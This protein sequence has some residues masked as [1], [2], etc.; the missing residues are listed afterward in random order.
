MV[1]WMALKLAVGILDA[2]VVVQAIAGHEI[3][4]RT[5]VAAIFEARLQPVPRS[6]IHRDLATG[7]GDAGL[8]LDVDDAG[9]LEAI[10]GRQR[11]GDQRQAA[12]EAFFDRLAEDRQP[13]RQLHAVQ[14]VLHVGVLAAQMDLTEAVLCHAGRLQQ[15]LVQRRVLALRDVLQRLGREVIGAGPE[16]RLDLL[17]GHVKLLGNHVNIDGD[18]LLIGLVLRARGC[19][20]HANAG[21]KQNDP[22]THRW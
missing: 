20:H 2:A 1:S 13:F 8:G 18:R 21:R 22:V 4:H 15:H 17:A 19:R 12:G 6:A 5:A 9:G 16:A 10:L 14:A 3:I 7:I 11:A